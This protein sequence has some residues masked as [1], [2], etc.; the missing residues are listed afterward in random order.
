MNTSRQKKHITLAQL[1]DIMQADQPIKIANKSAPSKNKSAP[2]NSKAVN[3][4]SQKPSDKAIKS[5]IEQEA[6]ERRQQRYIEAKKLL[7]FL[8]ETYPNCFNMKFRKPLKVGIDK[9]ILEKHADKIA[10]KAIL[11]GALM[12]Y[13]LNIRY[14]KAILTQNTRVNLE[15]NLAGEVTPEQKTHANA[16]YQRAL[17]RLAE[18]N[19][20]IKHPQA[21]PK[22]RKTES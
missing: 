17:A 7:N 13:T 15:G 12:V 18:H 11:N 16:P 2:N 21:K 9:D 5:P 8:C 3:S 1:K 19:S 6:S 20:K 22:A 4:L 14:W 10:N